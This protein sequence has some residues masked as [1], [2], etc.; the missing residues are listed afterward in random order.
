MMG[1]VNQSVGFGIGG[2]HYDTQKGVQSVLTQ[3]LL[4]LEYTPTP[5]LKFFVSGNFN[6]EWAYPL[7]GDDDKW[8]EKKFDRSRNRL[9][10]LHHWQD[11]LKE[12]NVTWATEHFYIKVGKQIVSWGNGRFPPH[13]PD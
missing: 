9:F 12:A 7:L 2:E 8:E 5:D 4:E 11:L 6:S 3:A 10:I 13:Q 1:Y